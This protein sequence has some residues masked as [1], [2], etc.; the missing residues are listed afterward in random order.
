MSVAQLALFGPMARTSDP[1]PSH[2]A[3]GIARV[4]E[5]REGCAA[6]VAALHSI[7]G[8]GAT[9]DEVTAR[10][11]TSG[12]RVQRNSVSKRLGELVSAG[13][14]VVALFRRSAPSGV[15]VTVYVPAPP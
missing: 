3:A 4:A 2:A 15:A 12:V 6:A 14:L 13:R 8:A 9:A 5:L 1:E 10:L 7:T 11:E